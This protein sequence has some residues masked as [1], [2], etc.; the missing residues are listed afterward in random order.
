[1][2]IRQLRRVLAFMVVAVGA[3]MRSLDTALLL[4]PVLVIDFVLSRVRNPA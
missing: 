1:M 3:R 4:L 2:L